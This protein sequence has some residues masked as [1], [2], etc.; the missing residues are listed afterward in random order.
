MSGSRQ[1]AS[2]MQRHEKGRGEV[3]THTTLQ[4]FY[5]HST[6]LFG[7]TSAPHDAHNTAAS[8]DVTHDA[9]FLPAGWERQR[10]R[11]CVCTCYECVRETVCV[12]V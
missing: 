5:A 12:S 4:L 7:R 8:A 10:G 9:M 1:M 3:P 2:F 6:P 11:K